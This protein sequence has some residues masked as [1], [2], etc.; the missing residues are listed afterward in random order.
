MKTDEM[1]EKLAEPLARMLSF[2]L[3]D[4]EYVKEAQN[5]Y[6]RVYID[7]PGGVTIDDWQLMS[8]KLS[9]VL[10]REDPIKESYILEVSS[11]GLERVLKKD[12]DYEKYTGEL[13]FVKLFAPKG[14]KKEY[15]GRLREFNKN[16]IYLETEDGIKTFARKDIAVAK[17]VYIF[18]GRL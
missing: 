5:M 16:E 4:T 17:R 18:N 12:R 8:E 14:E 6:L 11:P 7:K 3:V 1:I 15:R 9:A 10:D 2:E 13:I